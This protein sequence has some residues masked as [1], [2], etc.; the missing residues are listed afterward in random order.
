M[1]RFPTL[2]PDGVAFR[3]TLWSDLTGGIPVVIGVP[4]RP[5]LD[6]QGIQDE[7]RSFAGDLAERLGVTITTVVRHESVSEELPLL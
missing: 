7:V 6:N 2:D 4:S 5:D 3:I 1:I